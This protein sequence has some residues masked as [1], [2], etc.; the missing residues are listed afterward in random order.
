MREYEDWIAEEEAASAAADEASAPMKT[1]LV[2]EVYGMGRLL[3]DR[4]RDGILRRMNEYLVRGELSALL[5]EPVVS[6][7]I[8]SPQLRPA[9]SISGA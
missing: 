7:R 5:R 1:W 8:T 9:G 3:E 2:P 4:F 6:E